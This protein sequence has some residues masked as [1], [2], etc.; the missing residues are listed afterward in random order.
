MKGHTMSTDTSIETLIA[1]AWDDIASVPGAEEES[2]TYGMWTVTIDG[3][4][5]AVGTDAEADDA[6][7]QGIKGLVWAFNAD[8]ILAHLRTPGFCSDM[9]REYQSKHCEDCNDEISSMVEDMGE[10]IEDAIS[11]DGRG[12]FLALYDGEEVEIRTAD[13]AMIYAY[14]IN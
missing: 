2:D 11:A 7:A 8:F 9:L 14:R 12:H 6:C 13:G 4:T 3:E 10:F 5:Y 1:K